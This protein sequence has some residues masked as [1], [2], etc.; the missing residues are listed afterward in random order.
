[1]IQQVPT[2]VGRFLQ[3]FGL[4]LAAFDFAV[5]NDGNWWS[6]EANPGGQYGWIEQHT[7]LPISEAI[8]GLLAH[9]EAAW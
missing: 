3:R 7:G 5:D 1:M 4:P 9:E 2:A 6:L 8:A